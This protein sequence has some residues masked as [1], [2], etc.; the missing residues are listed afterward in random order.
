MKALV[1]TAFS[2]SPTTVIEERAKPLAKP[3]YSLVRMKAASI[4]QLSRYIR[5]GAVPV[6]NAPLVLGNEG[7]GVVEESRAFAAGTRVGIYGGNKVGIT[8]D[9]MF[10]EWL[11]V[12]DHR[13]FALP[14]SLSWEEGATLSVNYLTAYRS[15]TKAITVKPGDVVLVSGASGAVGG[16]T[17]QVARALG[18]RAIAL[19]SSPEKAARAMEAG[20][21]AAIDL[22]S[23]KD[24]AQRVRELTGGAGADW[25]VDPVGGTL[26]NQLLHALRSGGTVVLVGFTGGMQPAFDAFEIIAGE[27]RIV[28]Y[29]LHSEL[30][31]DL[32][33][34]QRALAAFAGEGR[35]KPQIDSNFSMLDFELGYARLVSRQAM[36]AIVMTFD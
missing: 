35:I 12:E 25:A 17:V 36:G 3:G 30:D 21:H 11:L 32:I 24:V 34:A 5:T 15:L 33:A 19:T 6:A 1:T 18:A 28:G 16:A 26:T 20:A 14:D 7:A 31:E 4:N 13:L 29:S 10:Q 23:G 22:S 9:G 8:E 2:T 27:K